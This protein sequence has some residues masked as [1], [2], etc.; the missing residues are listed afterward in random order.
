MFGLDRHS[1]RQS[2]VA[3]LHRRSGFR[4]FLLVPLHPMLRPQIGKWFQPH[5]LVPHSPLRS[6]LR[7]GPSWSLPRPLHLRPLR[8]FERPLRHACGHSSPL[9]ACHRH[10]CHIAATKTSARHPNICVYGPPICP[11]ATPAPTALQRRVQRRCPS[12]GRSR[13][14]LRHSKLGG[15]FHPAGDCAIGNN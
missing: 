5:V 10:R 8:H 14:Q 6:A 11:L 12:N 9:R 3:V 7:S 15:N 4:R 1:F 13:H 2:P